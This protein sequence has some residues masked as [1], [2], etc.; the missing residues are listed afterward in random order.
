MKN[1]DHIEI[2]TLLRNIGLT[3]PGLLA[4]LHQEFLS[5]NLI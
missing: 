5:V 3:K 4:V 1:I 2:Q